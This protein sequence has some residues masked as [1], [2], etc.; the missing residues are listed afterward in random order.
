MEWGR[1]GLDADGRTV[2]RTPLIERRICLASGF[3]L[4][5][6]FVT[7]SWALDRPVHPSTAAMLTAG[8]V[9]VVD[10]H[11]LIAGLIAASRG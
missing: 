11:E 1:A 6:N 9:A 3:E 2:R 10:P 4:E 8:C 7:A 5:F